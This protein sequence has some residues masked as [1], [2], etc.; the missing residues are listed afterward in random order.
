MTDETKPTRLRGW[1]LALADVVANHAELAF[2]WGRSDCL[3]LVADVALA[4]TGNDPL[5]AFRG[6]YTSARGAKRLMTGAGFAGLSEAM[7]GSFEE[8]APAMAR[9]GDCGLVE[10]QVRGKVV[11][12]AVVVTGPNVVGKSAPSRKGGTGL[13]TL[14]RDRLVRAYRIGW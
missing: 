11:L 8:V 6:R 13:T 4:L 14:G 12:A 5:A 1:E 7:A 2:A 9:R 10:T 3:T